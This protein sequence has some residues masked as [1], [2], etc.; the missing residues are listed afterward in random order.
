[1]NYSIVILKQSACSYKTIPK[2]YIPRFLDFEALL[3]FLLL[4]N[5]DQKEYP[6]K[7]MHLGI[8]VLAIHFN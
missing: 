7:N 3:D 2:S 8:L 4:I 5:V 6:E 1:M